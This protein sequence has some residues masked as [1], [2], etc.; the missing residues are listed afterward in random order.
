[1]FVNDGMLCKSGFIGVEKTERTTMLADTSLKTIASLTDINFVAIGTGDAVNNAATIFFF[2]A[3]FRQLKKYFIFL[4]RKLFKDGKLSSAQ[5]YK[6]HNTD[7]I[8][9][10]IYGLP[11]I[12]KPDVPLR[13][14]VSFVNSATYEL[15]K[16][17][18]YIL[19]PLINSN[20]YSVKNSFQFVELINDVVCRPAVM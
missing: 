6:L 2:Y 3:V 8:C 14:I 4:L 15:S 5:Y 16:H 13:P 1:M 11:K 9:P 12:H 18:C 20:G 17:L 19:S 10:R 7:A